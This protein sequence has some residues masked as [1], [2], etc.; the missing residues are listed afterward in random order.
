MM[1]TLII[2]MTA[3]FMLT[4]NGAVDALAGNVK[5]NRANSKKI[6]QESALREKGYEYIIGSDEAGR[7][8]IAGPVLAASCCIFINGVESGADADVA[9]RSG[10]QSK[11]AHSF[12]SGV[13]DSKQLSETEREDIYNQILDQQEIYK[14]KCAQRSSQEIEESNILKATMSCF[15]ESIQE[16]IL[17]EEIPVDLAYSIVDGKSTPKLVGGPTPIPCRPM[18]NA[19]A[20]VYT[21]ALAS[22]IAKVTRDRIMKAAHEKYPEYNFH[23]NNGYST[24]DHIERIHKYGPCPLHRMSFKALKHR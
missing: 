5:R 4:T 2:M 8:A 17:S 22:I 19:D 23:L 24:R 10:D 16:L 20:R 1:I 3:C 21:V 18:V 7:G 13:N 15:Q 6:S 11:V 14:F 12:I 9:K